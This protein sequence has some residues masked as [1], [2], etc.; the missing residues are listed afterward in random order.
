MTVLANR[1]RILRP[2]GSGGMAEVVA[3]HDVVLG[4]DVAVK[5]IRPALLADP[6]SRDRLLRE[7]R[8]AAALHHPNTVAVYDAGDDGDRPFVVLELVE[9][10]TLADRLRRDGPRTPE[11]T[12]AIGRALLEALEAAHDAGLVHRDIKPSNVLLANDGR[13]K[14]ADFGIAK[15]LAE[16]DP[17]LTSTGQIMGT[18]RYLAPEVSAGHPASAASDLYALGTVLYECLTGAPPFDGSTP[19]AVAL[20]HQNEP[21]PPLREAA[22]HAPEALVRVIEHALEKEPA[23]RPATARQMRTDLV[24]PASAAGGP[25]V[26]AAHDDLDAGGGRTMPLPAATSAVPTEPLGSATASEGGVATETA[27]PPADGAA[28]GTSRTWMNAAIGALVV[29]ALIVLWLAFGGWPGGDG[30][31]GAGSGAAAEEAATDTEADA[32]GDDADGEA[33]DA[34]E[35]A[36]DEAGPPEETGPESAPGQTEAEPDDPD[37]DD[38]APPADPDQSPRE[39]LDDLVA[40]LVL[41]TDAAGNRG[42]RLLEE[43]ME[44]READD[45]DL[46]EDARELVVEVAAWLERGHLEGPMVEQTLVTLEVVGRPEAEALHEVSALFATIAADQAAWGRRGS[47]LLEDLQDLLDE[48]DAEDWPEDAADIVE[49]LDGWIERGHLDAERGEQARRILADLAALG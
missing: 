9:G 42:D 26:A 12:F 27:D 3:A 28:T 41:D 19:V 32:D 31:D 8:S 2:L 47:D 35:G 10:G 11:E 39:L 15:A 14:L 36:P 30:D 17:G 24:T 18:P 43:L 45:E 1:Y 23:D 40:D 33:A 6:A 21:V 29:V 20:A 4:R 16:T 48:D 22:P 46:G 38:G 34:D 5:L 44:L 37:S 7:A 49:D 13:V 25:A